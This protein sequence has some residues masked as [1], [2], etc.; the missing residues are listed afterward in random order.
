M[1]RIGDKVYY[2]GHGIFTIKMIYDKKRSFEEDS[3]L[4]LKPLKAKFPFQRVVLRCSNAL[5]IGVHKLIDKNQASLVYEILKKNPPGVSNNR[6]QKFFEVKQKVFSSDLF[7]V[8]EVICDL[9]KSKDFGSIF[10][11]GLW[12]KKARS[13][14]VEEL[15]MVNGVSKNLENTNINNALFLEKEGSGE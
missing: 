11:R 13:R 9:E 3:V 14:L 2:P 7:K 15:S 8:A 12:L 4:V 5:K 1:F 10:F 6:I